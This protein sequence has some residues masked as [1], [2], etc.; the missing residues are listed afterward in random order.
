MRQLPFLPCDYSNKI[1]CGYVSATNRVQIVRITNIPNWYFERVVFQV[2]VSYLKRYQMLTW[3]FIQ[4]L[5]GL[6]FYQI[7]FVVII[8]DSQNL[9]SF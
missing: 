3:K 1:I 7:Q 8:Y 4:A 5:K 9:I 2:N 6:Q